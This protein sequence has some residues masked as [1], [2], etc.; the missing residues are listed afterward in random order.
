M[1]LKRGERTAFCGMICALA[2]VL[3]GGAGLFPTMTYALPAIAGAL[4]I[5][6]VMEAGLKWGLACYAV[7]GVLTLLIGTDKE[8]AALFCLLFGY[9]PVLKSRL[10]PMRSRVVQWILKLLLFNVVAL[11]LWLLALYVFHV[12]EETFRVA[13]VSLQW[14]LLPAANAVFV[15]YDLA[16]GGL[17]AFY[18]QRLHPVVE[19]MFHR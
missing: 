18:W 19:R 14:L 9:Y 11:C 10:D 12:P 7:V 5:A 15:L 8:S 13:G 4:L 3:V 6:V 2:A 17:A 1:L 16:L